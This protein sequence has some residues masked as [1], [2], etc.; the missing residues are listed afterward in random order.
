MLN[1]KS[2]SWGG[3]HCY[4]MIALKK[5]GTVYD[6]KFM[7]NVYSHN[8]FSTSLPASEKGFSL[9]SFCLG[10]KYLVALVDSVG[11]LYPYRLEE[12][13]K[14]FQSCDLDCT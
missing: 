3:G 6:I 10:R 1:E 13:L 7:E 8:C 4:N 5:G 2:L 12:L 11:W 9:V 14:I